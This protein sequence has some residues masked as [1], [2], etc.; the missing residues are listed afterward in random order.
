MI[1]KIGIEKVE[2]LEG[3]NDQPNWT[4]DEIRAI[5]QTY[6]DKTKALRGKY[7]HN[8]RD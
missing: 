6:K 4:H 7:E 2:F 3:P 1:D 5:K 8:K